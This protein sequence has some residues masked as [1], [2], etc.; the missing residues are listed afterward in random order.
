MKKLIVSLIALLYISS[1]C[2]ATVYL[3][4]CMGKQIGFS[5]LPENSPHC[6]KCGMKKSAKGMGCCKDEQK[7]LKSDNGQKL[8]DFV[9]ST[10]LQKKFIIVYVSNR[11][12][13]EAITSSY[14]STHYSPHGP[15]GICPVPGYLMNCIFLI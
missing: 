6:H 8:T 5:F 12:Y 1:S 11:V 15:P 13:S 9:F 3:H 4:Y 7:V 2:E 10:K 14:L